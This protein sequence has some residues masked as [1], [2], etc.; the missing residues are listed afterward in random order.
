MKKEPL[1]GC[2]M[3]LGAPNDNEGNLSKIAKQRLSQGAGERLNH[4]RFKILLT[5]G[6]GKHFNDTAHPHWAYAKKFLTEQLSVPRETFLAET[7]ESGNTV[8]D[9]EKAKPIFEKYRFDKIVVVTSEFH[10]KRVKFI[11]E[12]VFDSVDTFSFSGA[13]DKV[14]GKAELDRLYEHEKNA[15][16]YLKANYGKNGN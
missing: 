1:N 2:I 8:E 14:L 12:K 4:P 7:I 3:I 16:D 10:L 6:Y 13:S 5:G 15:L 11:I 9:I